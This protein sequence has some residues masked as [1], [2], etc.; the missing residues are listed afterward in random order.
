[1]YAFISR[2]E[3]AVVITQLEQTF[4]NIQLQP[5]THAR[6]SVQPQYIHFPI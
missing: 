2:P 1:M 4:G 5:P 3:L 6:P